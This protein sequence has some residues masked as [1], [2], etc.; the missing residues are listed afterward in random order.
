MIRSIINLLIATITG[1]LQGAADVKKLPV[2]GQAV[3]EGVI[4]KGPTHWG[5]AVRQPDGEIWT[6]RWPCAGWNKM[7]PWK[8]PVLRGV[9]TMAEML[10]EGFKAL[11]KSAEISLGEEEELTTK[12]IA[13][14]IVVS[15]I[16]VVGLFVALPMWLGDLFGTWYHLGAVGVNV[17]EGLV[18][19]LVFVSYVAV[20]GLWSDIEEV[21]RY[22]GA[23]HKTI[24]A[25]EAGSKMLPGYIC[26]YSRIHP[27]CGTSFLVVVVA[28]SIVVFSFIG[29]GSVLWRIGSRVILL[30]VVIGLSYEIIR[31]SAKW[32][33][34]GRA[35]MA[36]ALSLQYLTTR[37]PSKAQ[38]EIALRSLET[39]LNLSF[40]KDRPG[41]DQYSEP[42]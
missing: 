37:E 35:I 25:F 9:A 12:D 20:I 26:R 10:R 7:T 18:R 15:I 11:S 33:K 21:L 24:N 42:E 23:E 13:I 5:M 29:H 36:P 30:P 27:R 40:T 17:V 39:A 38:L 32:G 34:V 22:H 41:R 31:A 1:L 19:G 3:I 6:D 2:G 8:Y 16:A 4:M 14:S 28:M